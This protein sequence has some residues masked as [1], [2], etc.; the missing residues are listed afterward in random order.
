[1]TVGA[2][3][4][5]LVGGAALLALGLAKVGCG[6][7]TD[8]LSAAAGSGGT[9]GP[10]GGAG[11]AGKGESGASPAGGTGGAAG[12]SGASA[13]AGGGA[14]ACPPFLPTGIDGF[15]EVP[16][17]PLVY[18]CGPGCMTFFSASYDVVNYSW[19]AIDEQGVVDTARRALVY[20]GR[21]MEHTVQFGLP[22][23]NGAFL[24]PTLSPKYLVAR[25][26][27][28]PEPKEADK[29]NIVHIYDRVTG[30]LAHTWPLPG[31]A[32]GPSPVFFGAAATDEHVLFSTGVSLIRLDIVDGKSKVLSN[33]SC[34][35]AQMTR[36]AYTCADENTGMFTAVNIDTG[37]STQLAPGP[38]MQVDGS[39]AFDG[40][41]CAWV[42]YRDPPA[43]KSTL[44]Y[45][46]GGEVY[47]YDFA[48]KQLQ[49][50]TFDS[51]GSPHY[52]Y[53]AMVEGDWVVWQHWTV[54]AK[55][56]VDVLTPGIFDRL[57]RQDLKTGVRCSY[58]LTDTVVGNVHQHKLYA[59]RLENATGFQRV[60]TI[61]LDSPDIPWECAPA[62]APVVVQ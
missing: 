4:W 3:R 13:A 15:V 41:A 40:S 10:A 49:R 11:K 44:S 5:A 24:G 26:Y 34:Y 25:H 14:G 21:T 7:S 33:T 22:E 56:G 52:K 6:S 36:G 54:P 8:E 62:P 1:M 55:S 9:G 38:G 43:T 60:V 59:L 47:R 48:S 57:V 29:Q 61:D 18:D 53:G 23:G 19:F 35:V 51:P 32:D 50:L 20:R 31:V 27:T 17:C 39:C 2:S 28:K 16:A 12:N 42:D 58:P 46:L 37:S 30:K 45:R